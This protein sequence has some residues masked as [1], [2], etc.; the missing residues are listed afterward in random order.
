ML[1]EMLKSKICGATVTGKEMGYSG[2]ITLGRRLI[3]EAD[4]LPGEK[5]HV[6]NLNN[7]ARIETYAIE[8]KNPREVVLNGP[9]ARC[10]EI[11]DRLFI[12]SYCLLED[13]E[14]GKPRSRA[15]IVHLGEGNRLKRPGRKGR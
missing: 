9:A 3:R 13:S 11:G 2:S 1:R 12:L 7:G 5:V 4:I 14:A 6:L 10:G 15:R 8:G